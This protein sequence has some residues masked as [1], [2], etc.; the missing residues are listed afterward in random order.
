MARHHRVPTATHHPLEP[1]DS[2]ARDAPLAL[3]PEERS[4]DSD[5][6]GDAVRVVSELRLAQGELKHQIHALRASQD[7]LLR[8][9]AGYAELF[10]VA[11]VAFLTVEDDATI[12]AANA[13]ATQ[14]FGAWRGLVGSPL[15][16]RAAPADQALLHDLLER[17]FTSRGRLAG[18]LTFITHNGRQFPAEVALSVGP[19][20]SDLQLPNALRAHVTV[21][22]LT[23]QNEHGALYWSVFDAPGTC[24]LEC[25]SELRVLRANAS[26]CGLMGYERVELESLTLLDVIEAESREHVVTALLDLQR[27]PGGRADLEVGFSTPRVP[28][29]RGHMSFTW[30][31]DALGV[32]TRGLAVIRDTQGEGASPALTGALRNVEEPRGRV[33]ARTRQSSQGLTLGPPPQ[34]GSYREGRSRSSELGGS[35]GLGGNGHG[36]RLGISSRG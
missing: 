8:M 16:S 30:L 1:S 7:A 11:P 3:D 18:E 9:C 31:F 13:A 25:S 23:A 20:P 21:V 19:D 27:Y 4:R 12:V 26:A 6:S 17:T 36:K 14:L 29:V 5:P 32:P 35:A 33:F 24:I 10:E 22:D 28:T 34:G 15:T 2:G